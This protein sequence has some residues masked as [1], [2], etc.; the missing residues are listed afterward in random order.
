MCMMQRGC[1]FVTLNLNIALRVLTLFSLF[2]GSTRLE[3]P[4]FTYSQDSGRAMRLKYLN[5]RF[6]NWGH[7]RL[8][9]WRPSVSPG[10]INCHIDNY[11]FSVR[12]YMLD[13]FFLERIILAFAE[14]FSM[15]VSHHNG[16]VM[17]KVFP[18]HGVIMYIDFSHS[19][20]LHVTG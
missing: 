7:W 12:K 20:E 10:T 5:P 8:S 15:V 6:A 2:E 3:W 1:D 17:W 9:F 16:S 14:Y 19:W 13:F 11:R 4:Y 18:C